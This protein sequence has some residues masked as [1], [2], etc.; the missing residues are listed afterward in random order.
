MNVKKRDGTTEP[1]KQYKIFRSI[2]RA[3]DDYI[4]L[5][6]NRDAVPTRDEINEIATSIYNIINERSEATLYTTV[7]K[8]ITTE[9]KNRGYFELAKIYSEYQQENSTAYDNLM[10][11]IKSKLNARTDA[12]QNANMDA[13]SFGGRIGESANYLMK[14]YAINNC[15]SQTSKNNH[16]NNR[17]YIHDLDHYPVGD[18]NCLMMPIDK[19]LTKGF[20]TRSTDIRG[21][22]SV[23]T[24]FQL[25]AVLFQVQ[26]LN[27]FGG[28]AA[29]HVDWSMVPFVRYSFCKHYLDGINYI[30][31]TTSKAEKE[32][33][34]QKL[35][36]LD[37][38]K[39]SIENRDVYS[40]SRPYNY[41]M[42]QL[43]KEIYQAVEGFFHNL[44]SLES[45]A[46]NQLPFSSIN[47]GTCT[48]Q[49]GRMITEALL[50]LS[51]HGLGRVGRTSIFPCT[52]FQCAKGINRKPDD[53]NYDLFRLALE[54]TAKRL[55]P[56]Y[57]NIDWSG[58]AGYDPDDPKTYL[59]SMGCRTM[60]L[61]D[62]NGFGQLK[63]GRGNICPVT[64]ILPTIAME[65]K[66]QYYDKEK[67]I[68]SPRKLHLFLNHLET[69]IEEAKDTLLDRFDYI[70]SQSPNSAKFMYEN[71]TMEGY[72]EK[73]GIISA[74]KHGTL[75]MGIIGMAETL[76]ILID[77]NQTTEKGMIWAKKICELLKTKCAEYKEK[78][79]LNFGLYYSPAEMLCYTS[80]MKFK[81]KYG[82]I[83]KV[84]DK[85]FF[86]NSIHIPVWEKIDMLKKIKLESMLVNYSSAG[87][88]TYI[89]LDGNAEYNI[90]ALDTI[91]NYAMDQ[92]IPYFA[93]NVP[94]D[95]CLNCGY[96]LPVMHKDCPKC[97]STRIQRL[98]RVT[99]YLT[100]DYLTSFNEGKKNEV[101]YRI[102]HL[103]KQLE[104]E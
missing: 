6:A 54:S 82:E 87:C 29:G 64:I 7:K 35:K 75:A 103:N 84:S 47:F 22:K 10:L 8:I 90:D 89:E 70:A 16:L 46:G 52:I 81:E 49:E 1:L 17:V 62:I 73:E 41:A 43:E 94:N 66:Q 99:G 31:I 11:N 76:E 21:A 69:V 92:D 18:H 2:Q 56:N 5:K 72:N 15:L 51:I 27:M 4:K 83:P 78:Y 91:V 65:V 40:Y 14:E 20:K 45:R 85:M 104:V 80:M 74:L 77:Q 26:S 71:E 60:N 68:D 19:L 102:K 23:S 25:L 13:E 28:V 37:V 50:K 32:R 100:A 48:L 57:I 61:F 3:A 97:G 30:L 101:E 9:L 39:I 98:R 24:A 38:T 86:T 12:K 79:K 95:I 88:I 33:V 96:T 53:P 93:I 67:D 34:R 44:N 59:A 58:N 63:D 42:E 55:Y 36:R